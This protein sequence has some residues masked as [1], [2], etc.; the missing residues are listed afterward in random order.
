MGKTNYLLI[1][2]FF[3]FTSC[4]GL[5][6]YYS[7]LEKYMINENYNKAQKLV[8]DSKNI[9]GN[10]NEFLYYADLGLL[11]HLSNKYQQS[12]ANFEIAKKIYEENYTKSISLGVFSLFANDN[13][14]PY[15]GHYYEIAYVN[16]FCALNYILQGQDKEAVVEAKQIDNLFKKINADTFGKT[17]YNDDPFIRYFMGLVYENAG[18]YND[19]LISY[20][21][22]LRN[23][24]KSIYSKETFKNKNNC[25]YNLPVPTDLIQSLYDLYI[26]LG[27]SQEASNLKEKFNIHFKEKTQN[28]G[29][30]I[31]VNYNGLSPKKVDNII[32]LSFYKAWP[33]FNS[34]KISSK[35]QEQAEKVRAAVQA[36]FSDDYIKIAF[37]KY[38][39]YQNKISSFIVEEKIFE[40]NNKTKT[41]KQNIGYS[42]VAGDIGTLLINAL[43]DENLAI[44]SKTIARAVGRYVLSK[45]VVEQVNQQESKSNNTLSFLTN[46]ILNIANSMLEK[47]DTRSWKTLPETI[48]MSKIFLPEGHHNLTIK[49]LTS[50]KL[51]VYEEHIS[52]DIIK[53]KKTFV[54]T[55]SFRN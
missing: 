9:Y 15:Y 25:G 54:V 39:R 18:Y 50:S 7:K 1:L 49:Y 10:K 45:V 4:A 13:V 29:E 44:Y 51:V 20:K 30:L 19:A 26:Y 53:N 17:F 27:F 14:V 40:E 5:Q 12:N 41:F 38:E 46:S 6:N 42:Y 31:I 33:Y 22:A 8:T 55:K 21:L 28:Y 52:V 11:Y 47:A 35:E 24:D 2:I 48:N 34:T 23:Y 36:G 43:Q 3:I 32:E 37:P 16:I